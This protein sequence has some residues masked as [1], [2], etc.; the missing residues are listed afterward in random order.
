MHMPW[1]QQ[2]GAPKLHR[3][4]S[5]AAISPDRE[6]EILTAVKKIL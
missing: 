6:N 3:G 2:R 1:V 4:G 5:S